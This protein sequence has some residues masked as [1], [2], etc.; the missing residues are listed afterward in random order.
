MVTSGSWLRTAAASL[1][2]ERREL[3][4]KM[5]NEA[6]ETAKGQVSRVQIEPDIKLPVAAVI[7]ENY[8]TE[9]V[10]RLNYYQKMAQ[11]VED[12]AI[13]DVLSEIE[14]RYGRAPEAVHHLGGVMVIRR[15]LQRL[16]VSALSVANA[17]G[18]LK[19]GLSFVLKPPID[20]EDLTTKLQKESQHYR[21]LPS[22]KLAITVNIPGNITEEETIRKIRDEL[23]LLKVAY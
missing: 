13:W 20:H 6:V 19:M 14:D 12:E 4:E 15:R 22:G 9:P 17:N 8:I 21:L 1:S 3:G 10:N 11:A 16:G 5:L 23:S 2:V 7:P 18:Q